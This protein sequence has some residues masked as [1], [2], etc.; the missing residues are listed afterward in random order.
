MLALGLS[1]GIV[2]S[3]SNRAVKTDLRSKFVSVDFVLHNNSQQ[4]VEIKNAKVEC[5][6]T[7]VI[8][9][10]AIIPPGADRIVTMRVDTSER[11]GLQQKG[12]YVVFNDK[13]D[14]IYLSLEMYIPTTLSVSPGSLTWPEAGERVAKSVHLDVNPE[15]SIKISSV[16]STDPNFVV[17]S[18]IDEVKRSL[19]VSLCPIDMNDAHSADILIKYYVDAFPSVERHCYFPVSIQK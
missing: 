8:I 16:E 5:S 7:I 13:S 2:C 1:N 12:A 14:P 9:P 19:N 4:V 15:R 6:C 11:Q 17:K 10:K 3:D 18:T